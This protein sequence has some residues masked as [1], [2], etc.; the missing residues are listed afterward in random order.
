MEKE[1]RTWKIILSI[2]LVF[3]IVI[4]FSLAIFAW[5]NF[6]A[7]AEQFG[8]AYQP[9]MGIL[10]LIVVYNLC[11]SASIC[12]WSVLWIRQDNIAGIEAGTTVGFLIFIVSFMVFLQYDRVDMLLFDSIRAFL[13]V[14]F[15]VLA[16]REHKRMVK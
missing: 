6:P 4:A 10:R 16:Y 11:L 1:K 9:D 5:Y 15:G 7:L 13:M 3:Q 8:F 2:L 14:V 12:L